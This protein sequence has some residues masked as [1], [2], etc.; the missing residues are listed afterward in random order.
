VE[1]CVERW[2]A[3]VRTGETYEMECRFRR[4]SDGAYRWHLNR[5]LPMRDYR[6]VVK[7]FGTSTDIDDQRRAADALRFLAEASTALSSSLDYQTTLASVVRL[8]VPAIADWCSV[9]ILGA[10]G[11]FQAPTIAH[12]DPRRVELAQRLRRR[13][14]P[15]LNAP[16]G[17][18]MVV[19]SGRPELVPEISD[20]QLA[21]FAQDDEHLA[22]L[23]ELGVTSFIAVPLVGRGRTHGALR[24]EMAESG[25]RYT[26]ADLG[27]AEELARR[28]ALAIDNARLYHEAREAVRVRDQFLSIASHELKTPLTSLMGYAELIQRRAAREG[29]L[30]E[31]DRRAIGVIVDQS[32][33]LNRLIG[34]M[35]DLSRIETGQLSIERHLIDIG[36]MARRLVDEA[37]PSLERHPL[38]FRGPSEALLVEGDELRLEQVVQNLIQNAVKY[39]PE[40]GAIDVLVER[41]AEMACISVTDRGI[42]IP[43]DALPRLFQRFYRAPNVNPQ[44]ISGLGVGLYVVK[45]IVALH[46]GTIAV[47]SR[48]EQGSTFTIRLPLANRFEKKGG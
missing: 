14:P 15:D 32:E 10:D 4:A 12:A 30:S 23:R 45:E 25:R 42:G 7:W 46:G 41:C 31:R 39:S 5:A 38:L 29:S 37:Q 43:P 2:I 34:A 9:E 8:A 33:R 47:A 35:L 17:V 11:T 26:E 3:S 27:V 1:R 16:Y 6:G 22:G 28:A 36:T 18:G 19:R 48:E 40:G 44:Q 24:L 20:A 21:A 13:Y